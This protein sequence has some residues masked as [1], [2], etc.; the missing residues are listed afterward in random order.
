[1]DYGKCVLH[2]G[3]FSKAFPAGD[4]GLPERER[5][6]RKVRV[7]PPRNIRVSAY[8]VP[9]ARL[10]ILKATVISKQS[11]SQEAQC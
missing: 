5:N 9:A 6:V 1:M 10:I 4:S 3:F 7:C 2:A 8:W 11:G